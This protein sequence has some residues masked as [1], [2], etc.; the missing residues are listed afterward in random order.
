MQSQGKKKKI[1]TMQVIPLV[2]IVIAIV[3]I[4][5]G[6][7]KYGFWDEFKGPK[8]GF[9]PVIVSFALLL[10]SILALVF[11]FK[12]EQKF[13]WALDQWLLPLCVVGIFL[14]TT[15]IGLM[16][17]VALFVLLWLRLVEK[18]PWKTTIK[19]FLVIEVIVIGVFVLW[20]GVPFPKGLIYTLIF[21]R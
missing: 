8:P 12:E 1:T 14:A 19:T 3:F 15:I 16:P 13:V 21:G 2:G 6:L 7:T 18:S 9:F 20:L 5:L 4:V 10:G 11:S 17:S